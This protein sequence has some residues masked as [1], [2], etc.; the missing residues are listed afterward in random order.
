[1]SASKYRMQISLNVLN[2]L[3]L[4]LYS[5]RPAVLSE[6]IA[7]AWDADAS[8]VRVDFDFVEKS[9][10]ISDDGR[11]MN[12]DDVN[13]KFLLVG[14]KKRVHEHPLTT[15][16][17]KPMGRK[18]I[19]KLSLFSIAD[20]IHVYTRKL[21]S[22][23]ES[24]SMD[25]RVIRKAIESEDPSSSK[26]Y[27]PRAIPPD[28]IQISAHG[29][30]IKITDLKKV[31]LN[32][33]TA[34][35]L[36][37]RIA[38]R[39]GI[40]GTQHGFRVFVNK[41]EISV[42]DRGYYHKARFLF[43]Y[44]NEA[45]EEYC[46]NLDTDTKTNKR[47]CYIR[48][49]RFDA[50]GKSDDKGKFCVR[51][52]IAIAGQSSDLDGRDGEENLNRITIMVRGKVAQEDI[53]PTF[54]IGGMITKFLFGEIY[55]DFLDEDDQEDITTS[56]RQSISE[57]DSR[58]Q[59]LKGFIERELKHI[60]IESNTLKAR[61]GLGRAL[62]SNPLVK[63][64]YEQLNVRSVRN[65]A[66]RLFGV[67][68]QASIEERYKP[69]F[70]A[71]TVLAIETFRAKETLDTLQ[72]VDVDN[73]ESFLN[74]L[75]DLDALEAEKYRQI[76]TERLGVINKLEEHIR[77]NDY[78]RVIQDFLF[79]RLWLL[80]PAWERA[81]EGEVQ[82]QTIQTV[83]EGIPSRGR[84][85]IRYKRVMAGHVIVELKRPSVRVRK[86]ELEDQVR[87]YLEAVEK[88]LQR[89]NEPDRRLE[90]VCI[91]D[92]LPHGWED[93]ERRAT[94][95]QSLRLYSIRVITYQELIKNAKQA[96]SKFIAAS[97]ELEWLKKL[98]D[99]VSADAS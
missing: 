61:E 67:I 90:A 77:A 17:R 69:Q 55:A 76:V 15:G 48:P 70:Y 75:S 38:R 25:A 83:V 8:E 37:R 42:S 58:Y 50:N 24:F 46:E 11:G 65:V 5:N 68:E 40:I 4:N 35:S 74:H 20:T 34:T 78:E 56:G 14:Y 91:V 31:A 79:N 51:G 9:I 29:T 39:F 10:T 52:W 73:I 63:E 13:D 47:C 41:D 28:G 98:K 3:G 94:D 6:V 30:V 80:D 54:R 33:Q 97:S 19:G 22:P 60:W 18:G 86:T 23:Q 81:T 66:R 96:Y 64:W 87:K 89:M 44:G 32:L 84:I 26:V 36:K 7:N 2:H 88:E 82:E 72:L 59:A 92:A 1:M 85:D 53:L 43:R 16:G 21:D 27:Q 99:S 71:S 49:Y 95:E 45:F 93:A 62:R 57:D 12:L